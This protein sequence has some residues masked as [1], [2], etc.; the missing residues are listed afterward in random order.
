[1]GAHRIGTSVAGW[2]SLTTVGRLLSSSLLSQQAAD[3][4]L[5]GPL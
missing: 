1:M 3:A 4:G 5:S 2:R